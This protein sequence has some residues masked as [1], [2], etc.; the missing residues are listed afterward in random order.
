MSVMRD[1]LIH[2]YFGVKL[3][4]FFGKQSCKKCN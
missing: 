1:K 3:D 4:V 2:A